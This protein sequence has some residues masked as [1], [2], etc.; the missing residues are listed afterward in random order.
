[1]LSSDGKVAEQGSYADLSGRNDGA[2]TKLM[3]WQMSGGD[4]P[5]VPPRH[6][7]PGE[8][9]GVGAGEGFVQDVEEGDREAEREGEAQTKG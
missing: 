2:F 1:M 6:R 4:V 5:D 9:E 7:G 8:G 3:E